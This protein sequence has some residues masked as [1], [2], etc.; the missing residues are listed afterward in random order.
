[1]TMIRELQQTYVRAYGFT[2]TIT[3]TEGQLLMTPVYAS[4]LDQWIYHNLLLSKGYFSR[5]PQREWKQGDTL[6]YD[7]EDT[8]LTFV[9]VSLVYSDEKSYLIWAGP[10][11]EN[12]NAETLEIHMRM[13]NVNVEKGLELGLELL[14]N[15]EPSIH[16]ERRIVREK[17]AELAEALFVYMNFEFKKEG[18][19]A[20]P[21]QLLLMMS[22]LNGFKGDIRNLLMTFLAKN[23]VID[24]VGYAEN[25]H[26][27]EYT[28]T[29]YFGHGSS[30][31]AAASFSLG[32]GYLG[33]V[34]ITGESSHW[35]CLPRD[36]RMKFFG[37]KGVVPTELF[38]HPVIINS[39]VE[40]LL[41]YGSLASLEV[42]R[43]VDIKGRIISYFLGHWESKNR[44]LDEL[45]TQ[46][47]LVT[48][49]MEVSRVLTSVRDIKRIMFLLVDMAL[50]LIQ[51]ARASLFL[52]RKPGNIHAAELVTRGLSKDM[53]DQY[54]KF[55]AAK[56][57]RHGDVLRGHELPPK[58]YEEK[59]IY[60]ESA[61]TVQEEVVG[62]LCV[63]FEQ[64]VGYSPEEYQYVLDTLAL[65]GST[66]L[67]H[68]MVQ[69]TPEI[70]PVNLLHEAMGQWDTGK[71]EQ[72][73]AIKD[74]VNAFGQT[75]DWS[76]E[77][78]Q[79][80]SDAGLLFF[81]ESEPLRKSAI[82]EG[83]IEVIAS[84]RE[85]KI[86]EAGN[87]PYSDSAQ[88]LF[89]VSEYVMYKRITTHPLILP[90]LLEEFRLFIDYWEK[91]S[92]EIQMRQGQGLGDQVARLPGLSPRERE[93][94][95]EITKGRNNKD[96]AE[97]LF[98]SENTVKNH[99]TSIFNKTGVSDRIQLMTKVIYQI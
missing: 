71:Y 11:W 8:G 60:L 83:I 73:L 57:W 68:S 43:M 17:T 20:I 64:Q 9:V 5:F 26:S 39:D 16:L 95:L 28:V 79:T 34:A 32:E 69:K 27:N 12:F 14:R 93:V 72:T 54:G 18:N 50:N 45:E 52:I 98:I 38:C 3:D 59:G 81:Y 33:Q 22:F 29:H 42:P 55:L 41:F 15:R 65:M 88:L 90:K 31:L 63:V 61:V 47:S 70:R 24:F 19:E 82:P 48:T 84:C 44:L 96:I 4:D 1:M 56:Y 6:I 35:R 2:I 10:I 87:A 97:A 89:L 85:M 30:S 49:F 66:A 91:K 21:R 80:V 92:G 78:V 94:L 46:K 51:D 7:L 86:S 53:A 40:G 99:I 25:Q 62:V 76:E 75:L 36:P 37:L 77:A 23:P 13:S 74:L 58:P 67:K